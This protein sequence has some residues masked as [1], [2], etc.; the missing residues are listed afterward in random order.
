MNRQ[1]SHTWLITC[2]CLD[3]YSFS[4]WLDKS[5]GFWEALRQRHRPASPVQPVER[6]VFIG[7][8]SE[9]SEARD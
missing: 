2:N 7:P 3:M 4:D 5:P 8:F 9:A 6:V 1:H